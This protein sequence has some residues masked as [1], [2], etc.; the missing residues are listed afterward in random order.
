MRATFVLVPLLAFAGIAAAAELPRGFTVRLPSDAPSAVQG[1]V[2]VF[3]EPADKAMAHA[4]D[5]QVERVEADPFRA[6]DVAAAA[7]ELPR[8]EPGAS[9]FVDTDT[10]AYP[11]AFSR[12][13]DGDYI[14]QAVLDTEHDD[15]YEGRGD[16]DLVSAPVRMTFRTGAPL[17]ALGEG[18]LCDFCEA[19][20]LCRKDDWA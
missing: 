3:A 20:G 2:L 4:K 13:P 5:G 9:A 10:V 1:R 19:R 17:P 7:M 12:L 6:P 15:N 11:R 18:R 8:L 16:D 14:V